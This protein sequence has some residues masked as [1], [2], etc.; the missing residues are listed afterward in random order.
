M[1]RNAQITWSVTVDGFTTNGSTALL[2]T[3]TSNLS[4][5]PTPQTVYVTHSMTAQAY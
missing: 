1:N 2:V 4:W 5:T 3:F